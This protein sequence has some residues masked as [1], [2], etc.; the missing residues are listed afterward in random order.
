MAKKKKSLP[1]TST[2]LDGGNQ[3]K[4]TQ[5]TVP[6]P[7]RMSAEVFVKIWKG[8]FTI[9]P[10]I[11]AENVINSINENNEKVLTLYG[12]EITEDIKIENELSIFCHLV[13]WDCFLWDLEFINLKVQ[14]ISLKQKSQV[15]AFVVSNCKISEISIHDNCS[16]GA[17]TIERSILGVLYMSY[18]KSPVLYV[19]KDSKIAAVR[20]WHSVIQKIM[21]WGDSHVS[22]FRCHLGLHTPTQITLKNS[23]FVHIDF[24]DT[25][26]PEFTTL[27]ISECR[28]NKLTIRHFRNY[29]TVFFCNLMPL[30]F[31][32]EYRK[33]NNESILFNDGIYD[34]E[35]K[36]DQEST[37]SFIDSDLGKMQFINCDLQSYHNFEFSNTRMLDI[38]LAGTLLPT[39]ESFRLPNEK[40]LKVAFSHQTLEKQKSPQKRLAFSQFK[41]IYE[42]QGDVARSLRYLAYEMNAYLDELNLQSKNWR[43]YFGE[44]WMLRLNRFSTNYGNS[45][46]L[47]VKRTLGAMAICYTLFCLCLGFWFGP[48]WSTFF[49]LVSYAPQYLNPFRDS[50]SII[51]PEILPNLEDS[52]KAWRLPLSRIIDYLSRIFVAYFA[53]QTIQAFRKLGK[54]SG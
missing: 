14:S 46:W 50:D 54:S 3:F 41:K 34:F 28:V 24:D 22:L 7:K 2:S 47:G 44:R 9:T 5:I 21:I 1:A 4:T 17:I 30:R 42:T 36:T 20:I 25:V 6:P 13:L 51:P 23:D 39:S 32:N 53:Y 12:I 18:S 43:D 10:T 40:D 26:F 48:S 33:G 19:K 15:G 11:W 8:E 52:A 16:T 27:N 45:W 49:D 31:W 37:L 35:K 38:F 29:G